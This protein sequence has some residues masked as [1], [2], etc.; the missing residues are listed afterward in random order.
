MSAAAEAERRP[1]DSFLAAIP[2]P[3]V[4][5]GRALRPFSLGRYR[6]LRRFD[7]AFVADDEAGAGV[8]DLILGVLACSMGCREFLEFIAAPQR[9]RELTRWGKA[10]RKQIKRESD[11]SL[12]SKIKLFQRYIDVSHA[13]PR[14]WN[15]QESE[16][17]APGSHWSQS[18]EVTLR[19][20]LGWT[21]REI[22]EEPLS[23]ALA[24]FFALQESRG[25]IRIMTEEEQAMGEANAR[26][27]ERLLQQKEEP[28][29]A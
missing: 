28:H 10:I 8:E 7:C 13:I 1:G 19:S 25:Q 16:A 24:H 12:V 18:L 21:E 29:G 22:E 17:A 5:L 15:E 23:K 20:E 6:V 26:A 9:D 14:F 3:Y 11:F 4:I 27:M 2:E